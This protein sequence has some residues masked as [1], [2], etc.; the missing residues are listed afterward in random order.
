MHP[1]VVTAANVADIAKTVELLHGEEKQVHGDAGNTDLETRPEIV[2]LA[3]PLEWQI[4]AKRGLMK[5]LA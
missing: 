5:A 1:V 4:D 2:A 3:R